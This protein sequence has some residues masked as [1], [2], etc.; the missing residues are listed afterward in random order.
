MTGASA[1]AAAQPRNWVQEHERQLA[2]SW[3]S[4]EKEA[5]A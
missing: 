2:L 4:L 5:A 3:H 1:I